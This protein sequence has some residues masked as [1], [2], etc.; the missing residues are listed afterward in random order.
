MQVG[1]HADRRAVAEVEHAVRRAVRRSAVG[2]VH[3]NGVFRLRGERA[4]LCAETGNFLLCADEHGDVAA[5]L[6]RFF[7]LLHREQDSGDAGAVVK[8][9]AAQLTARKGDG[10][11][12]EED[13]R[14]DLDAAFR[15]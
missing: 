2:D 15:V 1:T 10:R 11:L 13:G 7:E 9:F 8:A 6:F 5:Q 12:A 14:T 4:G 3:S